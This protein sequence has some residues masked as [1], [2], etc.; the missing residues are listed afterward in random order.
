MGRVKLSAETRLKMAQ[1]E[2]C[3][4]EGMDHSE[5][6]GWQLERQR[7]TGASKS[8]HQGAMNV[9]QEYVVALCL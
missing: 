6:K 2:G 1:E 4:R 3:T 7:Y 8:L 9:W 5:E